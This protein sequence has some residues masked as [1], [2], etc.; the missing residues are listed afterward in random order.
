[1]PQIVEFGDLCVKRSWSIQGFV[2]LSPIDSGVVQQYVSVHDLVWSLQNPRKTKNL[3]IFSTHFVQMM[4]GTKH[5]LSIL[6]SDPNVFKHS[7]IK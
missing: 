4:F 1:M 5:S 2:V 6:I 3:L 7:L